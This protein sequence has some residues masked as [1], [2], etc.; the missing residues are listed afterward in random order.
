MDITRQSEIPGE[1][2]RK[3][4]A[5]VTYSDKKQLEFAI[6]LTANTYSNYRTTEVS[7][8]IEFT[9]NLIRPYKWMPT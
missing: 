9:K 8:P 1:L 3:A 2:P 4:Y 5:S 7:V 6:E